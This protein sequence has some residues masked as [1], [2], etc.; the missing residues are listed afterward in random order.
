[1][2]L[3]DWVDAWRRAGAKDIAD[4]I[5]LPRSVV[6]PGAGI[7]IGFTRS[8]M[9]FINTGSGEVKLQGRDIDFLKEIING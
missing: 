9:L 5:R 7:R 6:S 2:M 3:V 4:S 8:G 1:M